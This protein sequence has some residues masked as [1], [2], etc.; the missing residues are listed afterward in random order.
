MTSNDIDRDG[1]IFLVS[2]SVESE[3]NGWF[4]FL[5]FA[6]DSGPN[7]LLL[8]EQAEFKIILKT[9]NDQTNIVVESLAGSPEDAEALISKINELLS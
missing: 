5:N 2:Y 3:G 6:D 8:K 7:S 9:A 4:N 1:G